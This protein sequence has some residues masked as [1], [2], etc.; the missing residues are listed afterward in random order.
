MFKKSPGLFLLA[1][2]IILVG[3]AAYLAWRYRPSPDVP[4]IRFASNPE[5]VPALV[6]HD[7]SGKITSM[8][9]LK[10]KVVLVNFWATWCPP[11]RIEVPELIKLQ[12]THRDRL[13]IIGISQDEDREEVQAFVEKNGI[14]Y[15]VIMA[16]PEVTAAFGGVPA[17]PT[18]FVVDTEGRVVQRHLGFMSADVYDREIRALTGQDVNARIEYFVDNGQIFRRNVSASELPD[19]D[20]GNLTDEQKRVA[21]RR[22]NA[23]MCNCSCTLTLARCRVDDTTCPV[24]KALAANVVEEV[25]TGKPAPPGNAP[26][27]LIATPTPEESPGTVIANPRAIPTPAGP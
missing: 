19:V 24:S 9:D 7:L 1:A 21:L 4:V 15:P 23:E 22:L 17:L 5:P 12:E 25:R 11:C 10:G 8:N 16:T 13:Q 2:G 18:T 20:L 6:I 3:G 27:T 14:N 26:Q